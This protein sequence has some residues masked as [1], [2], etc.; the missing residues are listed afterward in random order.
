MGRQYGRAGKPR[1]VPEWPADHVVQP[2]GYA[3]ERGLIEDPDQA[4]H[5]QHA[6]ILVYRID[7]RAHA[8]FGLPQLRG[9]LF[10]PPFQGFIEFAQRVLR[11]VPR[12][13]IGALAEDAADPAI[14]IPHR[15][16]GDIDVTDLGFA[17]GIRLENDLLVQRKRRIVYLGWSA[18]V[19]LGVLAMSGSIYYH[20]V[21]T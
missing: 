20:F 14:G 2:G 17:A 1:G 3:V 9:A 6:H 18:A 10:H 15:C 16:V 13:D 21:R 12:G 7:Q 8:V 5:V 19:I 11:R 4:M